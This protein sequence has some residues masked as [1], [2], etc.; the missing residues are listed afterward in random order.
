[1]IIGGGNSSLSG[2]PGNGPNWMLI[3]TGLVLI[4]AIAVKITGWV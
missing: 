2:E 4:A 3:L 1:M